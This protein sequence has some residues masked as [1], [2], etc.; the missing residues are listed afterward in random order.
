MFWNMFI[1]EETKV[2]KRLILW[3]ALGIMSAFFLIIPVA[4]RFS[5][6]GAGMPQ[7]TW[8]NALPEMLRL[9][10]APNLA[11]L[12]VVVIV[13]TIVSQD[14][15]WRTIHLWLSHGLPRNTFFG[16]KFA[17]LLI[18]MLLLIIVPVAVGAATSA[19][20]TYQS[21]GA[22]DSTG[23]DYM[24]VALG[25]P[26]AVY[27]L[28]PYAALTFLLA[29]IGRSPL[30]PI[31]VGVAVVMVENIS[32]Q[33]LAMSSSLSGALQYLPYGLYAGMNHMSLGPNIPVL[34]PAQAAVGVAAYTA[35]ILGIALWYFRKQD[36]TD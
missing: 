23:L 24:Q 26:Q 19:L 29:L 12:V 30:L 4:L 2:F 6:E 7:V 31:A 21:A 8:P 18:P 3:I 36:L 28:L 10:A 25:I 11:G 14:Y 16:A 15:T 32:A 1:A 33:F 22:L 20:L 17:S 35:A 13:G 5:G 9:V 27:T 34:S